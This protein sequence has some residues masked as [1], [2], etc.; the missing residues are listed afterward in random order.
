[1][2]QLGWHPDPGGQAGMFRYWDGQSWSSTVSPVPLSGP[3]TAATTPPPSSQPPGWDPRQPIGGS[4][5][6]APAVEF[7]LAPARK[8]PAP[9]IFLA[10]GL[11]VIGLVVWYVLAQPGGKISDPPTP[12]P[13]AEITTPAGTPTPTTTLPP[14]SVCPPMPLKNERANHPIDARVYGGALSYT[15]LGSPWSSV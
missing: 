9:W 8:S 7:P 12:T 13:T 14:D 4:S 11:L 10:V 5:S 6:P 1:M 15:Q 2:S 3:P